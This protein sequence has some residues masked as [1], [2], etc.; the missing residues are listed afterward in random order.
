VA[1]G[2]IKRN[3][4]MAEHLKIIGQILCRG[5]YVSYF[6]VDLSYICAFNIL[7]KN[8]K[9]IYIERFPADRY[10]CPVPL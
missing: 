7:P 1:D 8:Q 10:N 4:I 3:G 6:W 2:K 5:N 9:K